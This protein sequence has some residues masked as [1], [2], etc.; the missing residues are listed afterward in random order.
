VA[1]APEAR[2]GGLPE[3]REAVMMVKAVESR[4]PT[5]TPPIVPGT[6]LDGKYRVE[7]PIQ[8]G[9]SGLV[10]AARHL[11]D[12]ARVALKLLN[13]SVAA[14]P[15]AES[16]FL[17]GI[18]G[19]AKLESEHVA[20]VYDFGRFNDGTPFMAMELLE[21]RDLART[22]KLSSVLPVADAIDYVLQACAAIAEAHAQGIVHQNLKPSNLFLSRRVDGSPIVKVLA[23]DKALIAGGGGESLGRG[24]G[25]ITS[26]PY[27]S[28]EQLQQ[29][30]EVDRRT[31][32]YTLG[33]ALYELISGKHPFYGDTLPQLCIEILTG[34]P[35]PLHELR[36][37]VPEELARVIA[38]AYARDRADRYPTVADF[39]VALTPFAPMRSRPTIERVARMAGLPAPVAGAAAVAAHASATPIITD[40][41]PAAADPGPTAAPS[42]TA[43]PLAPASARTV[44]KAG[45]D[46]HQII[47]GPYSAPMSARAAA[48]FARGHANDGAEGPS[49]DGPGG[50]GR[51]GALA[52]SVTGILA[53]GGVA[54]LLALRSDGARGGPPP[55]T[56]SVEHVTTTQEIPFVPVPARPAT[57]LAA[58]SP[59]SSSAAIPSASAPSATP[60]RSAAPSAPSTSPGT[61][62]T[63]PPR[64]LELHG[65]SR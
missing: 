30:G 24:A 33:I 63:P 27:V 12:D 13:P 59:G 40:L 28:P 47:L 22:L 49:A 15:A 5:K 31:D 32:I 7:L 61:P 11:P 50:I 2:A 65:T 20:R 41:A 9:E 29:G 56:M 54:M 45:S 21:G 58:E 17:R 53:L 8:H 3:G 48:R 18:E 4:D 37:E 14:R 35:T 16:R 62:K 6:I 43:A 64:P 51:V 42:L 36:P 39:V 34:T 55:P 57:S 52:L 60:Q 46:S 25:A 1:R 19:T 38:K 44:G 26:V 10:V 23:F